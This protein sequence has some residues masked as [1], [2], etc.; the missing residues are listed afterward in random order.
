MSAQEPA[1]LTTG[2]VYELQV[3][4]DPDVLTVAET[5][6]RLRVGVRTFQRQF[7]QGRF[8]AWF[9]PVPWSGRR[10]FRRVDVDELLCGRRHGVQGT[11]VKRNVPRNS[12]AK[13][14]A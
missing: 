14:A 1:H 10:L 13:G 6:A 9:K 4:P 3:P 7:S 5:A 11:T 8:P 2:G 12:I